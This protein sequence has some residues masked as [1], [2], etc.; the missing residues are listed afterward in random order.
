MPA[1]KLHAVVPAAGVGAR[2]GAEL[3]KQYLP[4]AGES[5]L[6]NTLRRLL[7]MKHLQQVVVVLG[8]NDGYWSSID[9]DLRA[10]VQRVDGGLERADSVLAGLKALS[11][12]AQ[13]EDLVLVH[14]AA[15]P[16]VR[17]A[18]IE[19]LLAAVTQDPVRGGLLATPVRDTMKRS[20]ADAHVLHTESR[21]CLWHAL[22]P[23]LFQ[24]QALQHAIE[25]A[26]LAGQVITDESS[27]MEYLGVQ[28]Q[29]VQGSDDNI[30]ITRPND[31]Q[32]AEQFLAQQLQEQRSP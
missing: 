12:L 25:A 10:R 5:I 7:S 3:P 26:Q 6:A 30:K 29:L 27:A 17:M 24:L 22:T 2:M 8:P 14:D 32:L 28:P 13:P 16:C 15:R 21:E 1:T 9:S 20:S 11:T 31:L 19:R 23:Q 18:D 4:L